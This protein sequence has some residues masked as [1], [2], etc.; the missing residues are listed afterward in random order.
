MLCPSKTNGAAR[1]G[2]ELQ[3]RLAD[4]RFPAAAFSH[5]ADGGSRL[6]GEA[7]VIHRLDVIDVTAEYAAENREPGFEIFDFEERHR[8]LVRKCGE[9]RRAGWSRRLRAGFR[10]GRF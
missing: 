4:R 8:R 9:M 5:E 2:D 3:D 10:R 6:D 7:D 1:G